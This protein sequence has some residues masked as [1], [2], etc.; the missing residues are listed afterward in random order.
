MSAESINLE[1]I[2]ASLSRLERLPIAQKPLRGVLFGDYQTRQI[3]EG[4][5]LLDM[6]PYETGDDFRDINWPATVRSEE[7]ELIVETH[8]AENAPAFYVASDVMGH[9]YQ[10]DAPDHDERE[11]GLGIA[12]VTTLMARRDGLPTANLWSNGNKITY[13]DEPNFD[14]ASMINGFKQAVRLIK[15]ADSYAES[16]QTRKR[17][18]LGRRKSI[19]TPDSA[20]PLYL[21]NLLTKL[22]NVAAHESVLVVISDFRDVFDPKDAIH[23]WASPLNRL[24]GNNHLMAVELTNK[25]DLELPEG[26]VFFRDPSSG[27]IISIDN[28]PGGRE[29]YA[30]QEKERTANIAKTIKSSGASH[31]TIDTGVKDWAGHLEKQLAKMREAA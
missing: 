24:A 22:G 17:G 27:Q 21:C 12:M 3:G 4:S 14:E 23:G 19:E 8:L 6:R 7:S 15:E 29:L 10:N 11:L 2:G 26:E 28:V 13:L 16:S 30:T 20:E 1:K 5:D 25:W 18:F 9:R 31:L